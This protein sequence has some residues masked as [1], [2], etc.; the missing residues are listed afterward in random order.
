MSTSEMGG[1]STGG[2]QGR[3]PAASGGPAPRERGQRSGG[4]RVAG[5]VVVALAEAAV[6]VWAPEW[7]EAVEAVQA[8]AA[9]VRIA[10]RLRRGRGGRPRG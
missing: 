2:E 3:E 4:G 10:L 7:V 6:R 5:R 9:G 1:A 8:V